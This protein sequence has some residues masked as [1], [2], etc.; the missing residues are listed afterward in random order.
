MKHFFLNLVTNKT[1]YETFIILFLVT[2]KAYYELLSIKLDIMA[3]HRIPT[4]HYNIQ[5]P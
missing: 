4:F 1:K 2:N 3:P 5:Q